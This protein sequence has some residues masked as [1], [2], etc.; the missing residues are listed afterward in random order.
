MSST[1]ERVI[2][3]SDVSLPNGDVEA[4]LKRDELFN[5]LRN[6]RRRFAIH[7]LKYESTAMSVGQLATQVAAWENGISREEVTAKQRRRV[8]N[9][10]QQSHVP[11]LEEAGIVTAERGEVSLTDDAVASDLYLE[12]VPGEDVPWS[13]YYLLLGTVGLAVLCGVWV[14][15]GPLGLLPDIAAGVFLAI[16]LIVSALANH[17]HQRRNLLG[18]TE[19]PPELRGK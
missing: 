17:Y 2:G 19:E 18:A 3:T 5:V 9:A 7:Y 4:T 16:S 14:D 15:A 13:K 12:V 1:A 8:Y 6:R 11:K 10:L